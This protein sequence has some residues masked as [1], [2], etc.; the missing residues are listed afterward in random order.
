MRGLI[1]CVAF[2]V[3]SCTSQ[4]EEQSLINQSDFTLP[5]LDT[6]EDTFVP[7]K[8]SVPVQEIP[9]GFKRKASLT[10]TDQSSLKTALATLASEVGVNYRVIG[11]EDKKD[12]GVFFSATQKP[13][14]EIIEDLCDLAHLRYTIKGDLITIEPDTPYLKMYTLSFP[15]QTRESAHT[16]STAINVFV[17]EKSD[18]KPIDNGSSS[19]LRAA[20]KS[21]FWEEVARVLEVILKTSARPGEPDD[22][23]AGEIVSMHKQAGLVTILASARQHK[24]IEEYLEELRLT[25]TAQVLIEAK[26]LEVS[27]SDAYRNG[28]NWQSLH[29]HF[30]AGLPLGS[31]ATSDGTAFSA[32]TGSSD[33]F[34]LGFKDSN[35][36]AISHF[37]ERFG[38][39]QTLSNPRL[40]VMNNQT[41]VLKVA[42]NEIFFR[43]EY[44]RNFSNSA[45][46]RDSEVA[47]SHIQTVPIG[48]VM[49]VQPA[50]N[51]E[52]GHVILTL[53][54]TISR[55]AGT[56]E[57][58]AV[59]YLARVATNGG[60][61][62]TIKSTVPVVEVREMDSVLTLY[63]GDV[64]LLG[65]LMQERDK[66]ARSGLPGTHD[67][68]LVGGLFNAHERESEVTELIILLRARIVPLRTSLSPNNRRMVT[69]FD[70]QKRPV[71][72][73]QGNAQP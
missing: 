1:F 14:I 23:E 53:R 67:A 26:I 36:S 10:L 20:G 11:L 66:R 69:T 46:G 44:N 6:E 15:V 12:R 22:A 3:A 13:F 61:V 38:R 58:P 4:H 49:T 47:A 30:V 51:L 60:Q 70:G 40:T 65:G 19:V 73:Q 39:V 64:A 57:D 52:T 28:I 21:D 32:E 24:M 37:I 7:W 55:I 45:T 5:P 68:P 71:Q 50:I 42:K 25:S 31:A 2:C 16:V 35:L 63:S 59:A 43:I 72:I 9:A 62:A 17:S 29:S 34:T 48:L 27:L 8:R 54:P 41:A 33:V 56:K 18:T